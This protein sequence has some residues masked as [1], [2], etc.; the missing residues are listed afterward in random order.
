MRKTLFLIFCALFMGLVAVTH[1][2]FIL[3]AIVLPTW[4]L[5]KVFGGWF[6]GWGEK[7]GDSVVKWFF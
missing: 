7:T 4:A 6:K 2:G 5:V 1:S 3:A